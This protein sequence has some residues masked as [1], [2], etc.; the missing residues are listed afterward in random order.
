MSLLSQIIYYH[1]FGLSIILVVISANFIALFVLFGWNGFWILYLGSSDVFCSWW[2][3]CAL[4][5]CNVEGSDD[6]VFN[7]G[8]KIGLEKTWVW[9][10]KKA[11]LCNSRYNLWYWRVN[12]IEDS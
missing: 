3:R 1:W 4:L 9:P 5:V 7:Y 6:I 12:W 10:F 8:K 2:I 11:K